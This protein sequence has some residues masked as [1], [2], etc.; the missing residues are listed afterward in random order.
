MTNFKLSIE[1]IRT[2]TISVAFIEAAEAKNANEY[3]HRTIELSSIFSRSV[4]QN[5]IY[6]VLAIEGKKLGSQKV[7]KVVYDDTLKDGQLYKD[8][9]ICEAQHIDYVIY[10]GRKRTIDTLYF[11]KKS[12][13]LNCQLTENID[14]LNSSNAQ[15]GQSQA[16]IFSKLLGMQKNEGSFDLKKSIKKIGVQWSSSTF[17]NQVSS[18]KL[19]FDVLDGLCEEDKEEL[20]TLLMTDKIT[21]NNIRLFYNSTPQKTRILHGFNKYEVDND[22]KSKQ[23]DDGKNIVNKNLGA[24]LGS[25][26]LNYVSWC[27]ENITVSKNKVKAYLEFLE[28][29]EKSEGYKVSNFDKKVLDSLSNLLDESDVETIKMLPKYLRSLEKSETNDKIVSE[30]YDQKTGCYNAKKLLS[31]ND[32]I[33]AGIEALKHQKDG[34]KFKSFYNKVFDIKKID[35]NTEEI[36]T[37]QFLLKFLYDCKLDHVKMLVKDLNNFLNV[38]EEHRTEE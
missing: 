38:L 36:S 9:E 33:L 12:F 35:K 3:G 16:S 34:Q 20:L 17:N 30:L 4:E 8:G 13:E 19:T 2:G 18:L 26:L 24:N 25:I 31:L 1:A 10:V 37:S 22:G 29:N 11:S 23:D 21:Y 14:G 6:P 32:N 15:R 5:Q 28:A 27:G 7:F